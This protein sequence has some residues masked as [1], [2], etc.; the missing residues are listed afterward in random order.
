MPSFGY[1]FNFQ[2][3]DSILARLN[4]P[5]KRKEKLQVINCLDFESSI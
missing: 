5:E 3:N 4:V 2:R 1:S